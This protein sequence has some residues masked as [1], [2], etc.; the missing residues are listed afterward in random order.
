MKVR[1]KKDEKKR[2]EKRNL[3][4]RKTYHGDQSQPKEVEVKSCRYDG[5]QILYEW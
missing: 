4:E 5:A 2:E 1:I 3:I